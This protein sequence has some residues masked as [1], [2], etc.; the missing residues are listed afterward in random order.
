MGASCACF[1]DFSWSLKGWL[2]LWGPTTE[3]T[4]HGCQSKPGHR[5]TTRGQDGAEM[6]DTV[7]GE[8][9]A[10]LLEERDLPATP[11]DIGLLAGQ[12]GLDSW[13]VINRRD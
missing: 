2:S 13:R 6:R 1:A 12:A 10:E 11:F 3:R 4:F 9:L 5:N 7:S 8:V